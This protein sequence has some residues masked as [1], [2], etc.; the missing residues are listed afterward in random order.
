MSY[1]T[2]TDK[3]FS[4]VDNFKELITTSFHE[5][6]NA[7][8]WERELK[9]NFPE[10]VEE[11]EFEG[12]MR[13]ISE[14]DLL[15]LELTTQGT[16]AR[17]IL[18]SDL[19]SL[20]EFG[21]SPVLNVI[22]SYERDDFFFP[23]DVY[24]WHVDRSPIAT[25]TFLC[26]YHGAPSDI[27]ANDQV[28]Q[29]ILIPEIR[30]QLYEIYDGPASGFEDFLTEYFFDL[31]YQ[32]KENAVPISLGIGNLWKLETDHPESKVLPCVHRAPIERN[33]E[34]RLLLIC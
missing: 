19:K 33:G 4:T 14:Q 9:G 18:L 30:E 13:I 27:I 15:R 23:T 8:C 7:L 25:A 31:H 16:V 22:K 28:E 1:N 32:E 3:H 34:K 12:K 11:I 6:G 10:I 29:K 24:S 21:A 17:E 5:V 2:K 20:Q 26:T